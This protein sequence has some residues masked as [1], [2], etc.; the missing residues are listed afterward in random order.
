MSDKELDNIFNKKLSNREFAFNPSNWEAMEAMLDAEKGKGAFYWWSSAAILVFGL[1]VSGLIFIQGNP[2]GTRSSIENIVNSIEA[3]DQ[4]I[5]GT[6]SQ[7]LNNQDMISDISSEQDNL[8]ETPVSNIQKEIQESNSSNLAVEEVRESIE[9]PSI[10]DADAV[11]ESR[12]S[13]QDQIVSEVVSDNIEEH[14]PFEV[15]ELPTI[16][17]LDQVVLGYKGISLV[18]Q[19]TKSLKFNVRTNRVRPNVIRRYQKQHEFSLQAGPDFSRSIKPNDLTTGVLVGA[20][21]QY[22]FSY[23][24]SL[25]VAV[26][27]ST[28][29]SLGVALSSDSAFLGFGWENVETVVHNDR[30]DYI[31]VPIEIAYN[32]NP[33]HQVGFGTYVSGIFNVNSRIDKI[34]SSTKGIGKTTSRKENGISENFRLLDYGVTGSYF[35]QYS[36][37][38]AV[39]AQLKYGLPDITK[40]VD[41]PL[42]GDD[43]NIQTR[44]ILKYRLF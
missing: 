30:L 19:K 18:S 15:E 10:D 14:L 40:N 21:Y 33:K 7:E 38:I 41:I 1:F 17:N 5:N 29:T 20:N 35:Y 11:S 26:N 22:R 32:I 42:N 6:I 31:E 9:Q 2:V 12:A 3:N 13:D 34:H 44:I 25:N 16:S 37:S 23:T 8:Q 4:E 27:Y 28:R 39:G 36:P 24:W 43:Q